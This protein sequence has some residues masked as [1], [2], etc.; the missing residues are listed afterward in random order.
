VNIYVPFSEMCGRRA[1]SGRAQDPSKTALSGTQNLGSPQDQTDN[2]D[3]EE[4]LSNRL[5]VL[6]PSPPVTSEPSPD[7]NSNSTSDTSPV[8]PA[9]PHSAPRLSAVGYRFGSVYRSNPNKESEH[10]SHH[11]H[12]EAALYSP[13]G[14]DDYHLTDAMHRGDTRLS[15][16][17]QSCEDDGGND[18][19]RH[20][21]VW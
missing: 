19:H 16:C 15:A 10:L 4:D 12:R 21:R 17:R 8:S 11:G 18:I 2:E 20:V 1:L 7:G 14:S 5:Q 6:H 13:T 3:R 9:T